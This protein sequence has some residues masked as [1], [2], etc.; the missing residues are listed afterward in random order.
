ML[1][2]ERSAILGFFQLKPEI[3]TSIK[4]VAAKES[5]PYAKRGEAIP[6]T[7]ART[8][9]QPLTDSRGPSVASRT[10]YTKRGGSSSSGNV[11]RLLIICVTLA[12]N[13][14]QRS[15]PFTCRS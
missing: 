14:V 7:H 1:T 6:R 9:A 4:K 12:T 10:L 2:G 11:W 15:Q 13:G 8:A 3:V 5:E